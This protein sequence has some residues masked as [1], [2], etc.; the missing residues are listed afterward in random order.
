MGL[1]LITGASGGIGEQLARQA[2]QAGNDVVLVARSAARLE[3]LAAELGSA[4]VVVADLGTD[5]GITAVTQAVP[6]ADIVVNNAGYGEYGPFVDADPAKTLGMIHLNVE[7]LTALSRFYLPG[8][9]SKGSGRILNMASTAAFTPGPSMTVY[10]ATKAYVLSFSE[11][12][13][14][15]LRGTGVTVTALCPGPT[16]SGFFVRAGLEDS[17]LVKGKK[18]SAAASVAAFGWKQMERGKVVAV[19]GVGNKLDAS[20]PR[21]IPRVLIRRIVARGQQ[22]GH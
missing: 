10:Y 16:V 2:R 22:Q 20:S 4:Q 1:A 21:F 12:L 19:P 6:A 3:E 7:A 5:D 14:E 8:M 9:V 17:K 13:A 18:L 15:E 11:G